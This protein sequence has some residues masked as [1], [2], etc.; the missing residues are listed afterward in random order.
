[1]AATLGVVLRG[2][3]FR[4]LLRERLRAASSGIVKH[5]TRT[6]YKANQR[7]ADFRCLMADE[8]HPGAA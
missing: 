2:R 6:A 5:A 3:F 1:M 4:D 7:S 8:P